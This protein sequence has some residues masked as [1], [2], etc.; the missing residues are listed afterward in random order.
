MRTGDCTKTT[1]SLTAG[2]DD[3][4]TSNVDANFTDY[5]EICAAGIEEGK[6][7]YKLQCPLDDVEG[8]DVYIF[9]DEVCYTETKT[10]SHKTDPPTVT[11]DTEVVDSDTYCCKENDDSTKAACTNTYTFDS[12]CKRSNKAEGDQPEEDEVCCNQG[13]LLEDWSLKV[14]CSITKVERQFKN[15]K[16]YVVT[17]DI[18]PVMQTRK[19]IPVVNAE[20]CDKAGDDEELKMACVEDD[21]EDDTP[22]TFVVSTSLATWHEA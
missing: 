11:F 21:V 1:L 4:Q 19:E 5:D 6:D 3:S 20:C 18:Y 13:W 8:E 17:T 14:A 16:C 12:T 15:D 22:N 7:V 2:Q 9:E 10:T